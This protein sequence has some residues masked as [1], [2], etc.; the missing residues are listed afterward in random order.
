[1]SSNFFTDVFP[2]AEVP[3]NDLY[4]Q[5]CRYRT[6]EDEYNS[7]AQLDLQK[8][9]TDEDYW[10]L[11]PYTINSQRLFFFTRHLGCSLCFLE[12]HIFL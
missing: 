10:F 11:S 8:Y 1:M 9:L 4:I 3:L 2:I 12:Y 5:V 6:I 7:P